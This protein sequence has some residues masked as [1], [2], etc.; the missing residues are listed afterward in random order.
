MSWRIVEANATRAA[1]SSA[2]A[3]WASC[4][5][6]C[7]P[8]RTATCPAAWSSAVSHPASRPR[9]AM[10]TGRYARSRDRANARPQQACRAV[11]FISP[12]RA[13]LGGADSTWIP[14]VSESARA[15]RCDIASSAT[16]RPRRPPSCCRCSMTASLR[17]TT[18]APVPAEA[19]SSFSSSSRLS[20]MAYRPTPK[21][22]AGRR[23]SANTATQI[24]VYLHTTNAA[25]NIV[26][27]L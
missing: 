3:V 6:A 26:V 1:S 15:V 19:R 16:F 12:H 22:S 5:R 13:A 8:I 11:R 10:A 27:G 25:A 4:A 24:W 14:P 17:T 23:D 20:Q 2:H 21:M 7:S 18:A 9:M